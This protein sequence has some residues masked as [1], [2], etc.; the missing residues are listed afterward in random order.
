MSEEIKK[1][2]TK[3][4]GIKSR[5]LWFAIVSFVVLIVAAFT[6]YLTMNLLIGLLVIPAI[7]GIA[8]VTVKRLGVAEFTKNDG[9]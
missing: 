4:G 2:L 6:G 9:S 7:Y 5:K 1:N 8:N 3:D